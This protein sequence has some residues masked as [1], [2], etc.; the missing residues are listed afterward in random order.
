MSK[1]FSFGIKKEESK[2]LSH[3]EIKEILLDNSIFSVDEEDDSF[4]S[5]IKDFVKTDLET[6][7]EG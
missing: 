3:E 7:L 1:A 6:I 2:S 4:N 5:L